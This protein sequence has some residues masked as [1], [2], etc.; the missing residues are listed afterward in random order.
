MKLISKARHSTRS[1][2][3]VFELCIRIEMTMRYY[4]YEKLDG[5]TWFVNTETAVYNEFEKTKKL[6]NHDIHDK[7]TY[8]VF[9]SNLFNH[10]SWLIF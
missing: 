7:K 2:E 4:E 6:I 1:K 3:S 8:K 10:V 9:E 5:K